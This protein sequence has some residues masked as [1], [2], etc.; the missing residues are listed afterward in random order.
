M[1]GVVVYRSKSGRE[2]PA[3]VL[4]RV[5]LHSARLFFRDERGKGVTRWALHR[6]AAGRSTCTF[7]YPDE[8]QYRLERTA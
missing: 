8:P 7:R 2:Y 4:N 6:D 5:G 1:G 3:L